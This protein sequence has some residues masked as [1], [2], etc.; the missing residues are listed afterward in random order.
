MAM[1]MDDL[2]IT[3]ADRLIAQCKID[4]SSKFEMTEIRMM[5]YYLGLELWKKL[6]HIFLG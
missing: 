4:F 6:G 5:L 3:G 2:I 1:Y